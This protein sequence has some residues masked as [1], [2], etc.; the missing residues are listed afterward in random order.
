[1]EAVFSAYF[2]QGLDIGED[3]VLLGIGS[4]LGLERADIL[5]ALDDGADGSQIVSEN[6]RAHRLGINGVPSYIFNDSYALAGA[7]ESDIFLRLID[8]ARETEAQ[9]PVS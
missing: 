8:L 5:A 9:A 1:M 2:T 3:D 6:A 7:Q 4:E